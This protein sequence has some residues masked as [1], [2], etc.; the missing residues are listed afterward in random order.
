MEDG[1]TSEGSTLFSKNPL[2]FLVNIRN[3]HLYYPFDFKKKIGNS[4]RYYQ[5]M[6]G[7]KSTKEIADDLI[8]SQTF[9]KFA[10]FLCNI[11][12]KIKGQ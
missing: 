6:K 12:R 5:M 11:K 9:L 1:Y 10:D 8:V 2:G 7:E 4:Y 3:E